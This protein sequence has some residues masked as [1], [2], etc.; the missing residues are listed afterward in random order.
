MGAES[1]N[2]IEMILNAGLMVQFVMLLLFI[3]SVASWA[4]IFIKY[5]YIRRAYRE[6]AD[7][8]E[9]FWETRDFSEAYAKSKELRFSPIARVFR[10]A[11]MELRKLGDGAV[12]QK[13]PSSA[14]QPQNLDPPGTRRGFDNV[15]RALERSS[16][17]ESIRLVQMVPFLA[18][19]GNIAPFIG[20]FGTVWGIMNSFHS[21]AFKKGVTS[22]AAVAPGISEAL[23]ATAAGLAVAIPAVIAFNYF[24]QKIRIIE[25]ELESFSSDFLNIVERELILSGEGSA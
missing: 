19:T 11:Y 17:T 4:I 18:T 5:R 12:R 22:I 10:I 15:K 20:L 8:I 7:F 9:Y 14:E 23:I 13:D 1:L 25:S 3:F 21:I 6:S 2:V 24:N 16:I